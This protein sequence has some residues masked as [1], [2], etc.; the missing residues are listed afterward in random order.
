[1]K[2]FDFSGCGYVKSSKR[3]GGE[4]GFQNNTNILSFVV[5]VK[6]YSVKVYYH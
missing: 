2:T 6:Q 3:G 4:G 5:C 1:M